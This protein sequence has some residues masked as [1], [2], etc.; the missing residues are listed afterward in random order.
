MY[1]LHHIFCAQNITFT[2]HKTLLLLHT[3]HYSYCTQRVL[4]VI[5]N[6]VFAIKTHHNFFKGLHGVIIS[7]KDNFVPREHQD[8][9]CLWDIQNLMSGLIWTHYTI[10][11]TNLIKSAAIMDVFENYMCEI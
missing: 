3:N 6:N 10:Y 9:N 11:I 4:T 5:Y 8:N 7:L 1:T 2:V